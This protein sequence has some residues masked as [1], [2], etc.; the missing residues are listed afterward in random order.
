MFSPGGAVIAVRKGSHIT[1]FDSSSGVQLAYLELSADAII[2]EMVFSADAVRLAAQVDTVVTAL[3]RYAMRTIVRLR[4]HEQAQ[5]MP[6]AARTIQ[7]ARGANCSGS[8]LW[9]RW[10]TLSGS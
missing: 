7:L 9:L 2:Q 8:M 4:N 5:S 3:C 6:P 1:I 10:K